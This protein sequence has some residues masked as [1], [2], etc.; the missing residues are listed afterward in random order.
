MEEVKTVGISRKCVENNRSVFDKFMKDGKRAWCRSLQSKNWYLVEPTFSD[1][2][3]VYVED[4]NY[5]EL[6]KYRADGFAIEFVALSCRKCVDDSSECDGTRFNTMTENEQFVYEPKYY[7]LKK[8]E[9][10][11]EDEIS[12]ET[13]VLCRVFDDPC[14]APYFKLVIGFRY[15]EEFPY[16]EN[17]GTSWKYAVPVNQIIKKDHVV[18]YES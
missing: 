6:R 3:F 16:L 18:K 13:P 10:R 17:H 8:R 15:F 5:A 9:W 7:R 14:E 1:D 11:W 12:E 2:R 4:D